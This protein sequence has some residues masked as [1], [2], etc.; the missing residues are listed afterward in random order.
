MCYKCGDTFGS[1]AATKEA[2]IAGMAKMVPDNTKDFQEVKHG[3]GRLSLLCIVSPE[4]VYHWSIAK[5][6]FGGI[7]TYTHY[8]WTDL[9]D[10]EDESTRKECEDFLRAKGIRH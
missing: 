9:A 6:T 2:I 4:E 10:Y 1:V 7:D 8:G 3:D 5:E